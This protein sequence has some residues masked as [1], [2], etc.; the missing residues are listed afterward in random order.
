MMGMRIFRNIIVACS[1]KK[2]QYVSS[3]FGHISPWRR[4]EMGWTDDVLCS[5][6]FVLGSCPVLGWG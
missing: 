2:Y 1:P 6:M 5:F 4:D 3:F